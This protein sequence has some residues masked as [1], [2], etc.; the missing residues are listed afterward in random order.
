MKSVVFRS[1][2]EFPPLLVKNTAL[3]SLGEDILWKR[4]YEKL[5]SRHESKSTDDKCEV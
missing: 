2:L 4:L 3:G 1:P 5:G